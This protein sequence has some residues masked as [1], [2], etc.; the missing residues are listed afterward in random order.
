[1]TFPTSGYFKLQSS[2]IKKKNLGILYGNQRE[3]RKKKSL[4]QWFMFEL[5][6]VLGK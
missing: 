3:K 4:A 5:V 6:P 2:M 1:V